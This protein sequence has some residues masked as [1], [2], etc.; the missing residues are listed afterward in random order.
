MPH[1]CHFWVTFWILKSFSSDVS[2]AQNQ[3]GRLPQYRSYSVEALRGQKQE[4]LSPWVQ[5]PRT[6]D[7]TER[8]WGETWCLEVS[9]WIQTQSFLCLRHGFPRNLA[10]HPW[11]W[12]QRQQHDSCFQAEVKSWAQ[13]SKLCCPGAFDP[14][15]ARSG[16][17][18]RLVRAV[19]GAG[20]DV[21]RRGGRVQLTAVVTELLLSSH[22]TVTYTHSW[23]R[24]HS[25]HSHFQDPGN[26]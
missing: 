1:C 2:K 4:M 6:T 20:A 8:I 16:T 23:G 15:A 14:E 11:F 5:G 24:Q 21:S 19:P 25:K 7:P 12:V 22:D 10:L 18:R 3:K 9:I 26:P 13:I 17:W